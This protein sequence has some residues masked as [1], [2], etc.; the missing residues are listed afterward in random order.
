MLFITIFVKWTTLNHLQISILENINNYKSHIKYFY[1]LLCIYSVS[2]N[3]Y[4]LKKGFRPIYFITLS[5]LPLFISTPP[6]MPI[7][8][9]F[10]Q[11]STKPLSNEFESEEDSLCLAV[12]DLLDRYLVKI[13]P[14]LHP[15]ASNTPQN[16]KIIILIS[17]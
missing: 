11:A 8:I 14:H 3:I 10:T 17:N 4:L 16:C 12:L 9:I 2:Y 7:G 5:I 6:K 1:H 15:L 13:A